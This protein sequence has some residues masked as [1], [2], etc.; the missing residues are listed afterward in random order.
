MEKDTEKRLT[1]IRQL[2]K[3]SNVEYEIYKACEGKKLTDNEL[4]KYGYREFREKYGIFGS[5]PAFGC[6]LSH[7][8]VYSKIVSDNVNSGLILED[9]SIIGNEIDSYINEL[10]K[11]IERINQPAVI[12][13]TPEFI[14]NR[15]TLNT[16]REGQYNIVDVVSGCMTTGYIVNNEGA[17]LLSQAL[18]PVRY[19]ADEW[20]NF[21]K[22]GLKIY[23][24]VPHMISYSG[25]LGEIGKSQKLPKESI[26]RRIRHLLGRTKHQIYKKL[27]RL[28]KLEES[29]K[30]W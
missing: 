11:Y 8:G 12:L 14:Y 26:P 17:R 13:L 28:R 23:G 29:K 27:R 22:F 6:C 16:I 18:L 4:D 9:D 10:G 21:S 1:M 3:L 20:G 24:I 2:E 15:A 7:I 19:I 5:L 25:E 30:L